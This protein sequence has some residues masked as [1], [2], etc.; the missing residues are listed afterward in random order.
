M[1]KT[2]TV[3]ENDTLAD[4]V[5]TD[6]ELNSV[7]GGDVDLRGVYARLFSY[8]TQQ[9]TPSTLQHEPIHAS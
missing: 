3:E 8:A 7:C 1:G 9:T 5:L 2:N 6:S 4:N